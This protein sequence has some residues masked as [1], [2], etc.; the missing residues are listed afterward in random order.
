M[1]NT[2]INPNQKS[3]VNYSN[4]GIYKSLSRVEKSENTN[5]YD[6]NANWELNPGHFV[7]NK[8]FYH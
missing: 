3:F 5:K 4:I 7:R 8:V 1:C 6:S 2:F